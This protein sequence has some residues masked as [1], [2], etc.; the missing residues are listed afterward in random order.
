MSFA[1]CHIKACLGPRSQ[2]CLIDPVLCD[3]ISAAGG[4]M[5]GGG[6]LLATGYVCIALHALAGFKSLTL[7]RQIS[8]AAIQYFPSALKRFVGSKANIVPSFV[9]T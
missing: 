5:D 2:G 6:R 9:H 1:E 7:T 4:Q 3:G 8:R